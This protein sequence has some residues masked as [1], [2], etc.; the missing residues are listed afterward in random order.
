[1]KTPPA[2]TNTRRVRGL[3]SHM[4]VLNHH[5]PERADVMTD[6]TGEMRVMTGAMSMLTDEMIWWTG[7][8]PWECIE[9]IWWTVLAPWQCGAM[10]PRT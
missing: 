6:A 1:M 9:M 5:A 7:L 2:P 10:T 3:D 4:E 8:A